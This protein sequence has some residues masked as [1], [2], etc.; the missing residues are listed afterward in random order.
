[1]A[2]KAK[3]Q[4]YADETT[5]KKEAREFWMIDELKDKLDSIEYWAQVNIIEEV[6]E[7]WVPLEIVD[8]SVNVLVPEVIDNLYTI[9]PNNSLSAK[10][11]KILYDMIKNLLARWRFLSTWNTATWLPVT[12]PEES[13]YEYKAWDYYIVGIVAAE[14]WTN[15][16][17]EPG[18]YVI[19]VASDEQETSEVHVSDI[20]VYDGEKWILLINSTREIAVDDY[21][22]HTYQSTNPVENQAIAREIDTKQNKFYTVST[23]APSNPA[24]WDEWYDATNDKVFYWDWT[25]WK[26]MWW[27]WSTYTAW[28]HISIDPNDN[29]KIS[30]V[31]WS[32]TSSALW[33]VKLGSDT[34]QTVAPNNVSSKS[35][36]TYRIQ[37]NNSWQLMVNVPWEDTTYIS[38]TGISISNNRVISC[39]V[40]PVTVWPTAPATPGT[41]DLWYDTTKNTMFLYKNNAWTIIGPEIYP[42]TK[43]DYEALTPAEQWDGR[44]FLI[45]DNDWTIYVDWDNVQNR[46]M[47]IWT[48]A[49]ANPCEWYIWYDTTNDVLK[50]YDWTQWNEVGWGGWGC[51]YTAWN[52]IDI[53]NDEISI[54]TTVVATKTDLNSKQDTLTAWANIT[55]A[56]D[57]TISATDTTYTAWT[58]IDITNWV[59][60]NTQTSAEWWNITGTL[61]DQT[62]L[63]NALDDKQ[64]VLVSG[65]NIKTV[66]NNS[67]L[68]S[69][70]IDIPSG[71]NDIVTSVTAP[72][73]HTVLWI[74]DNSWTQAPNEL[75][76]YN[77]EGGEWV[78]F[79]WVYRWSSAPD[80]FHLWYDLNDW[81]L[82]ASDARTSDNFIPICLISYW[83]SAETWATLWY[84]RD[85][86]T[87]DSRLKYYDEDTS[88]W[89]DI[90]WPYINSSAPYD[91]DFW[92]MWWLWVDTS[93]T[94]PVIKYYDAEN[95]TW[96]PIGWVTYT[97]WDWIDITN[98]EISVDASDLAWTW[99]STDGFNNL[100]VDTD[101]IQGKLHAWDWI[102]ID[103]GNEISVDVSDL[104]WTWL[105]TDANDNLIVD[106]T[107]VALKSDL[108]N[109]YTKTET[110]TKTEVDNLISS[111]WSFEVVASLPSV[112]TASEKT[113]YLLG[114]I[115][116]GADK[117]EEWIVT[118]DSQQQKQ[119]TKIWETSVDLSNYAQKS[120]VLT[121]TNT[122]SFTPTWDYQPATKKYVDDNKGKNDIVI[123]QYDAPADDE[124]I[125]YDVH[126]SSDSY[127]RH[128]KYYDWYIWAEVERIHYNTTAP[129]SIKLWD[130]WYDETNNVLKYYDYNNSSWKPVWSIVESAWDGID[131]TNGTVSV[132]VTDI[133]GTWLSE[134]ANNNIIVDTTVV[135]TQTDLSW[136]QDKATSGSTA[137]STTPTYVWQQYIDTT[138][139][140]M[141]VATGT[142]SSSDWTEV[143]AWSGDMLYSDFWWETLTWASVTL[144]LRWEIEPSANFTVNKPNDLKDWQFYVLRV[145]TWATAYTM[146]L[147][148]DVTNPYSEDLTLSANTIANFTFLAKDWELE[149]QP[150]TEIDISWKQDKATSW[151]TAPSTTPSYIWQ[152]YVDTTNNILYVAKWT[153]SSSDWIVAGKT[154]TAWTNISI[155]ANNVISATDTT[156]TAWDWIDITNNIISADL[157]AWTGINLS[158]WTCVTESDRK[159]PCPSGFHVPALTEWQW[160]KTIMTSV[161][162][163]G[164]S[165]WI[166]NL[167]MPL[168]GAR[169][170]ANGGRV[171]YG[172][173]WNY[174]SSTPYRSL[175][176]V[177]GA[178]DDSHWN[179]ES[180]GYSIRAFKN[181][182]VVPDS[183]WTVVNWTLWNA[184]IFWDQTNGLISITSDW[185]TGYTMQDKN[186]WATVVYNDWDTLT[187]AN[188]GNLYQWWNNYWFSWDWTLTTSSTKVDAS[189]YW[190]GNYYSSSTFITT[191]SGDNSWSSVRNDN[192]WWNTSNST[193]QECVYAPI[194][195]SSTV[196]WFN[197][198]NTGTEWQVLTKTSTGYDWGNAQDSVNTKT[199]YLSSTSDL[200]T[201]QAAY[202]WYLAGKN[203][204]IVYDNLAYSLDNLASSV[205][206]IFTGN[207][208][209]E[210]YNSSYSAIYSPAIQLNLSWD[211][212]TSVS[213]NS[214]YE[215]FG[216]L[217]T[218]AD[219]ST[220]YT[221]RYNWSPAT[222]KYVDD[223]VAWA[224]YTAWEWIDITNNEISVDTDIIQEKLT[225]WDGITIENVCTDISDMQ[226]P[227]PDGFHVPLNTEWQAM[228]DIWT[229]LDGWSSDWT[230]FWIALKLPLAG[231]RF[232]WSSSVSDQGAYGRYR[233]STRTNASNAYSIHF[234]SSV[235]SPQ[236]TSQRSNGL[237]VRCFKNSPIVPTPSWTKLYWMSIESWWIFWSSTDWLIS[238][239]SNWQTWV[240]IMDKNL[241]ATTVWN[242]GDTLSEANCGKYYQR[243]NNYGFPRTWTVTTSSTQVDASAYW[244]WN[245]YS[246]STFITRSSSPYRWDT[247]DNANLRWWVSQWSSQE[248]A[249]TISSTVNWF[250]PSNAWTEWQVL[251]KT[252][253]GYDWANA[254]WWWGNVIAMT[255]AE[256]NALTTEEKNDWKLRI[257]T[258][259]PTEDISVDWANIANKPI[260][261]STQSWN[262][263][264][265]LKIWVWSQTDYEAL[266]TKDA[267]TLYF[268]TN[269]VS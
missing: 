223:A 78:E 246:S 26:E 101:V 32:A 200:A 175:A 249:L 187:A 92:E 80:Y 79:D 259:A 176:L 132:D 144:A 196:N 1:M 5:I 220:P 244:P 8:K 13:P 128:F 174:Q 54:D 137:P 86:D 149:L 126:P 23:T 215:R 242:S 143:G 97:A 69:W 107:V 201:A 130:L 111:F 48:T 199:F 122:T 238:L 56:Q 267:S 255:Q 181:E 38:W 104:A 227:A 14:G 235:I 30:V 65:T 166:S 125:W 58:G 225:A 84:Y 158:W 83:S 81:T 228:Y 43:A 85:D 148:T 15:F 53:T 11:W 139:D 21:V 37:A 52:G 230:N 231:D 151:S 239:S 42:I 192:L 35:N 31:E 205:A 224:W 256:Y 98:N 25:Q 268:T 217:T 66:N 221:P 6:Q 253:T 124:V 10:Q 209:T 247:T 222:K 260:E 257:I 252:S 171:S 140:K 17:P 60:T 44:F 75:Y 88:E 113:I 89:Q 234:D 68:G 51:C 180:E 9:D 109:Y 265:S 150:S 29:N 195:I 172:M 117:Y 64:D 61:S 177:S 119:W 129:S 2:V 62:D 100:I 173:R 40:K 266:A 110:Y 20:Y 77:N 123:S 157:V 96:K 153:S 114:P 203:P 161:S 41:W 73:D 182:F 59:I 63:Q 189:D 47:Y 22:D 120:E 264:T 147:G 211:T 127:Y 19:N 4:Y 163:S 67:L 208:R 212:V 258:D 16:R 24:E 121:K 168:A 206:L 155:D 213:L 46:P 103:S 229:A 241:W 254:Q 226:W 27:G 116:T 142:S 184:W 207:Y 218:N 55:I 204:I 33:L 154:Y 7:N 18:E 12:N 34:P 159:W 185:T 95:T 261:L 233:S 197:P 106:S 191:E 186:L 237:S 131:I 71:K 93:W 91:T 82:K 102:N 251:T 76:Y 269:I 136:K 74:K 178:V 250:N 167:H 248:C 243:W 194:T 165:Y 162:W 90:R 240:T 3:Q 236:T 210:S 193:H 87:G 112:S 232:R 39:T 134:D 214:S 70:N 118:E 156:Y 202:N 160:L 152:Q 262:T 108:A 245:Y 198:S 263:L 179:S 183:S 28:L 146:T 169:Y 57:W 170:S 145:I 115:W 45:T 164:A 141:Y 188:C 219:Y 105:S 50:V 133:I 190:P 135:A 94:Y 72:S 99:L 216:V 138:A 36:R 49:P